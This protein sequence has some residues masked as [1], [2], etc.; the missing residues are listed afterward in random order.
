M[1]SNQA[2]SHGGIGEKE[3]RTR[4]LALGVILGGQR[5]GGSIGFGKKKENI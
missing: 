3:R 5:E 2:A 4:I 1:D